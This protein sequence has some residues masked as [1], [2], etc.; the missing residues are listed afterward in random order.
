M[1]AKLFIAALAASICMGCG[2]SQDKLTDTPNTPSMADREAE[3]TDE[4]VNEMMSETTPYDEEFGQRI[5]NRGARKVKE[6]AANDAPSGEGEV[7]V[8]FDGQKG[9]VVDVELSYMYE[10]A[11][12]TAQ[13]CIK[14]AFIG[15]TIPPFDGTKKVPVTIDIPENSPEASK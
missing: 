8:V 3:I 6:C 12:D 1:Q 10:S 2:G 7:T 9:R 5:L 4:E 13:K 15:E 14:N 11:G